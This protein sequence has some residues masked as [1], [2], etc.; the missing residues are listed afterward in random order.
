[1]RFRKLRIAWSV[2]WTLACVLLI[3]LRVRSDSWSD[4]LRLEHGATRDLFLIN[5]DIGVVM[6]GSIPNGNGGG[7][8]HPGFEHVVFPTHPR[9][10]PSFAWKSNDE[11]TVLQFPIWLL[12]AMTAAL[13]I[14]PWVRVLL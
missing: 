1:M 11:L 10:V 8:P 9:A 14:T 3:V 4:S 2:V 5:S 12:V 6:L 13:A 7:E